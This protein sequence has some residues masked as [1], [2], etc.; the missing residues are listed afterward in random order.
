MT[1]DDEFTN[2]IG[3]RFVRVEPGTF[4]MGAGPSEDDDWAVHRDE[5]PAHEVTIEEPFYVAE[6]PVTNDQFE[7]FDRRHRGRRG[8]RGFSTDDDEAVIDVSWHD[9]VAFCDWLADEEDRPYRLPTEAEWEFACRAGTRTPFPTGEELPEEYRRHQEQTWQPTPVDLTVGE[10]PPNDWGLHDTNGLVEE[11]CHDWYGPYPDR[12]RVDPVGR[13][14]G[15][16]KVTRGG[17][18]NTGLDYLR[19][20]NRSGTLPEDRHWLIGF[21]PVVRELPDTDP[22]PAP[23]PQP[24]ARDVEETT[25]EWDDRSEEP[26][27]AGPTRFVREPADDDEPFFG[28]NHCPAVTWCANGDLLAIWFSTVNEGDREM[29]ILGSRLRAGAEEWEP[30][31]EFFNAPDRN[32][33]GSALFHDP[34][35][36]RLYHF[37]GLETDSHWANLALVMRTS[38]DDGRTWSDPRFVDPNHRFR[39]QVIAGTIKTEDGSLVQPCD[40]THWGSGGTA[41][42]VSPDEGTTWRD[43]G[44]DRPPVQVEEGATGGSIAGI[45]AGVVEL[46][47]GRL[48]ALGRGDEIGGRMTRSVSDDRGESWTYTESPFPAVNG[49]QRIVLTRLR[50]GPLL[51]VGFTDTKGTREDPRGMELVAPDGEQRR[52]YGMFAAL[53]F[54]EGETWPVRR[55]LAPDTGEERDHE[56]WPWEYMADATHAEFKGYLAATQTPD[57]VV[58]LLSSTWHYR[59]TLGWLTDGETE[60]FPK[61]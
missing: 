58:H 32:V 31:S 9:A 61:K 20:A 7:E 44:R 45:H 60:S 36:G 49:G 46:D 10:T 37:N 18:H 12:A 2:S 19:S 38:D 28:H 25:P 57:G 13:E 47:D 29:T 59:F 34:D 27:F 41:I 22:L 21:R 54:D 5:R 6:T 42:H 43:P 56:D 3:M 24:W 26:F 16:T 55:L 15:T 35:D 17:S 52:C 50:E 30:A 8:L 4:R 39:N 40:A 53:S 23:E 51:Y 11:W 14:T 48:M 1:G 33:T